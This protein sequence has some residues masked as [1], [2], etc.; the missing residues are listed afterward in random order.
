MRSIQTSPSRTPSTLW[1]CPS[2]NYEAAQSIKVLYVTTFR[3]VGCNDVPVLLKVLLS[4]R[5]ELFDQNLKIVLE[6]AEK[7]GNFGPGS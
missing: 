6:V 7:A 1:R 5:C 3:N 2:G 4:F